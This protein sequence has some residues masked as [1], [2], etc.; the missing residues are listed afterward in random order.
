MLRTRYMS[1]CAFSVLALGLATP[2]FAQSAASG[3][4]EVAQAVP[5]IVV[6]GSLIKGT[7]EDAAL[8]V[9]VIS[10]EEL[11]RQGQPSTVELLKALPTSNGVLGDSNQFDS[12]SQGAEG[13]ATVN[14]RG[15]GP[16]RTL[17][18]LNN[19]R[20]VSAGNGIPSV[21]I[22]MIP[23]AAIGRIEVLKDGAAATY[24][25]DAVAGV[26]NFLT[27]TDQKG[28]VVSASHKFVSDSVGD[29]DISASFGHQ[30]NGFRVLFAAGYQTRGELLA[31]ERSFAI[32]PFATNPEGGFTGGGNPATFLALGPTG[33]VITGFTPDAS[34]VPLGGTVTAQNRCA[35]QYSVYDALVDTE[36]RGQAYVEL[37]VDVTPDIELEVTALYGRSTV[38]HYRTSPSYLLTQSPSAA[39]GIS[40]SGFFVPANNPGLIQYKLQNPTAIPA[41]AIGVLFPT[42]LYRPF[43]TGGNPMFADDPNDPGASIGERKSETARFT[44]T[45]SGKLTDSLDFNV[46]ATYQSYRRYIDGYDSF[47]DRVQLALRGLGGPNCTTNTPGANGC[48]WLNPFGNAVQSN[49]AT[50]ATNPNYVS[51]VANSADLARWFFVKSFSQ[52]YTNLFV[53]EASVSGKTGITLPG[54]EVQFGVGAQYRRDS[55]A[56]T[57]GN[58]NNIAINPC[59]ETPVTG[60]VGPC[61][62]NTVGGVNP[63]ATGA[64]AFLGTNA[65][66]KASGD[67]IATYAELQV[68]VFTSLNLQLAA[69]YEDYGGAVGST[70]N[71]Q[72]RARFQ[73]TP[74]LAFR[75]G[76]GTT[77]RGPRSENLVPGSITSLQLVGTSFRPVDVFG[78]PALKPES[79]TNYSGGVMVNSGGF[80]A[81]VDYFHYKLKNSILFEPVAGMV[82]TLFGSTGTANCG[83]AAYAALQAR[84]TFNGACGITNV[85][86]ITTKTIN[87]AGVQNSGLDFA[88]N[89]RSDIGSARFGAGV[90]ATYTIEYKTEDQPVDGVVVQK[91]FDAAGKLNFQTTAYPVPK[92]KGQAY[93]DLGVGIFDGRLTGTYIDGYHDQRSDTNSGPFAPRVDIAG[94]PILLQGANIKSYF[95]ADFSLR[96]RLPFDTTANLTVMN[97]FDRDPS[98][99]RL[100]Y[101]YDPFTGSALGRNYKIGLTKKF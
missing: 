32:Q 89:Y 93:I 59:R 90:T 67:V 21:D 12:R 94:S 6:T 96:V 5:D 20:L 7:P 26:V 34:C 27:K 79:S 74:W 60:N 65:N 31:R 14:L 33:A 69:R 4:D 44:A 85:A 55:Y 77:F 57:Y 97:I 8:P 38:P 72:G 13:I 58:N 15:L 100:D 16:Q 19:K 88:A 92:W 52:V 83:V 18:L 64:L 81:S 61:R 80:T 37:G 73:A 98:F 82:N 2:A 51:A 46:N 71:P 84:F 70:F 22:N 36:R 35:T 25:S 41:S 63:P 91:A 40:Q 101:N 50:G 42:L 62:P 53:G 47:G 1:A 43:L 17:V 75:A 86:R 99:A 54:G 23:Q 76:I 3:Q 95:T 78:N 28:F 24:G 87:G 66:A 48:M 11:A 56:V 45:L 29:Y 9:D 39:A 10:G 68:P 30:G 49:L